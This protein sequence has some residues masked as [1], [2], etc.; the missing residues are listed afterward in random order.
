MMAHWRQAALAV[1]VL[2]ASV[3]AAGPRAADDPAVARAFLEELADPTPL[4]RETRQRVKQ[5]LADLDSNTWKVRDAA[6]KELLRIGP[7]AEPLVRQAAESADAEA[8]LRLGQLLESYEASRQRGMPVLN[9]AVDLLAG[10]KDKAVVDALVKLLGHAGASVRHVAE[11]G[12]RRITGWRF[13][14]N[15]HGPPA[16][17]LAAAAKWA[18]WW[19]ASRST[20]DFVPAAGRQGVAGLLAWSGSGQGVFLFGLDGEV[21]WSRSVRQRPTSADALP[22]GHIVVAFYANGQSWLEEHD[23]NGKVVWHARMLPVR[24]LLLGLKRLPNGNTL[25]VERTGRR[26]I[27]IDPTGRE[28]VWQYAPDGASVYSAQ[29]LA[30]GNTLVCTSRGEAHEVSPAGNVVWT[31]P[32]LTGTREAWRLA[33]GNLLIVDVSRS[34]VVELG[35]DGREVWS[36]SPTKTDRIVSARRLPDGRTAVH[37]M[38]MGP[39]LVGR[40]GKVTQLLTPNGARLWACWGQ[41]SLAPAG[42][43]QAA[44]GTWKPDP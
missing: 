10:R 34:R 15:A 14:Y 27:E 7:K 38:G 39:V 44:K 17:R 13:G 3:S 4:S 26:V 35:A 21:V 18:A 43:E 1:G 22:N 40:D 30:S 8:A 5:L 41:I 32:G 2:A 19:K 36:W 9:E 37:A 16:E 25:A 29:R 31:K 28:I 6:S 23:R 12:L 33:S 42:A 20:F 24:G 11:Y